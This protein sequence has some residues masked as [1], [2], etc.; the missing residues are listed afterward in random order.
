MLLQGLYTEMKFERPSRI[1]ATTLPMI[2]R[3]PY[4]SMIAQ[5]CRV[6]WCPED[7][8]AIVDTQL[9]NRFMC[10][11]VVQPYQCRPTMAAARRHALCWL[12]SAG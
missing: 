8:V 9:C 7:S 10:A 4:R 6:L 3:P 11:D 2:L 12:C 5:A 1:Q